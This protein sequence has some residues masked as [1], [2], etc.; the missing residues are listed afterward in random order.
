MG[1]PPSCLRQTCRRHLMASA[2]R[3]KSIALW[4]ATVLHYLD[5]PSSGLNLPLD[6]RGTAFQQRVWQELCSIP[7]GFT[8]PYA[9]IARQ[10]GQP[11]AVRAV[12]SACAANPLAVVIPC[13]RVVRADGTLSGYRWGLERKR[14]LLRRENDLKQGTFETSNKK[15]SINPEADGPD[16]SRKA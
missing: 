7:L 10:I 15:I 8:I 6:I 13:H 1:W 12:A 11:T 9:E 5:A 2:I 4:M 3:P 14:Q 16:Q